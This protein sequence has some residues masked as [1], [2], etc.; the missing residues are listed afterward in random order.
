VLL[1]VS[2]AATLVAVPNAFASGVTSTQ[3]ISTTSPF[4]GCSNQGLQTSYINAEVEPWLVTDPA[5]PSTVVAAWQQDRW[6]DPAEGGA[7][8]LVGWSSLAAPAISWAPFSSC[9]GG[10]AANNGNYDRAT[11]VWLSYGP[12]GVVYQAALVF[13][14]FTGRNGVT[15]STSTDGG[16]SWGN[17]VLVDASSRRSF[18]HGDD[19]SSI[20]ADPTRPGWVYAVWDRYSAQNPSFS[21]GHGQNASKGPAYF[22]RSTDDGKTWSAPQAIYA[23]DNGTIGNQIVVLPNGTLADFFTNFVATNVKGG[24]EFSTE[25]CEIR[26]SDGGRTWS[27]NP[28]VISSLTPNGTFDPNTL[29]YI[30]AGD[31][32]FDVAV[33]PSSGKLYVV[34]EDSRFNGVDQVAFSRSTD[35]GTTWS[36]A[37]RIDQTPAS[38]NPLDEQAFT[39]SVD[40]SANGTL[41]VT[42]YNFQNDT[43]GPGTPTDYWAITS[44]DGG[45]T[46][47]DVI[48]LTSSSFDAQLAPPSGGLMI[49]DYEGL[50]HSGNSFIAAYEVT[51]PT[52]GNP[53]DIDLT[54]FNP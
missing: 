1:A 23:R 42:Y 24:V 6:G 17:P 52:A 12:D 40:V 34:W 48:R 32:L 31:I 46:W 25:L 26:S 49:G 45:S 11:D 41:A 36:T 28:V 15:V 16:V 2:I 13:D 21:D 8:G 53:T 14:W 47:P 33:D 10:S 9:S 44:S 30:R 51:N 35:G 22:S 27:Q 43:G 50:T 7:Q 37:A 19:K 39:P 29:N 54:G 5:H 18:T 4:A 20:T 38:S 3:T